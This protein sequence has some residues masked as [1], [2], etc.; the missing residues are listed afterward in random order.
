MNRLNRETPHRVPTQPGV[1]VTV[2]FAVPE[3]GT[4]DVVGF[5]LG[6]DDSTMI[7]LDRHGTEHTIVRADIV[8]GHRV[9]VSRGRDPLRMPTDL[10]DAMAERTGVRGR[11]FVIRLFDLLDG[12]EPPATVTAPEVA[13]TD[14]EW[15]T[16]DASE[17]LEAVGWWAARSGVRSMQVRTDDPAVA[18]RLLA[19]GFRELM[20]AP[21]PRTLH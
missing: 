11:R 6:A 4:R 12:L 10:L 1:R 13:T 5:V 2:R 20:P 17:P 21:E 7:V 8:A 16:A 3:G 14:G 15:V 18:E 19:R 9:P